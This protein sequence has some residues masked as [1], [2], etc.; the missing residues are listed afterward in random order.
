ML[1]HAPQFL[2]AL[3]V[4]RYHGAQVG[5]IL[6]D[7]ARRVLARAEERDGFFF[8][9]APFLDQQEVVDQHAFLFHHLAVGRHRTGVMPPTSRMMAA[10]ADVKSI[11]PPASSNTG[12]ITV[13]SGGACRRCKAR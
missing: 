9:Q 2:H 7:V 11:L 3:L 6:L 12:V 1:D 4:R 5:E 13:M 8:A 10:R